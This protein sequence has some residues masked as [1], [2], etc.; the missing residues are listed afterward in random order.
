MRKK[1]YSICNPI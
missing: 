1:M